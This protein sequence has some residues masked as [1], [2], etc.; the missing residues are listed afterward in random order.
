MTPDK[1]HGFSKKSQ[2]KM[3]GLKMI[4]SEFSTEWSA[5]DLAFLDDEMKEE[6]SRRA[7]GAVTP[8]KYCPQTS[9]PKQPLPIST[10][11]LQKSVTSNSIVL[12]LN[13]NVSNS[14]MSQRSDTATPV[15]YKSH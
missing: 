7:L 1:H 12:S 13:P 15:S 8:F 2:H 3:P 11:S 9:T 14:S 4:A 6:T 5:Q 10:I